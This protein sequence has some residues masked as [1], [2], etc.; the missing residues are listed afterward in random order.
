[1]EINRKEGGLIFSRIKKKTPILRLALRP[2]QS[3]LRGLHCNR[4]RGGGGPDG[5]VVI[6][7]RTTHR[8]RKRNRKIIDEKREKCR[9][10]NGSLRNTSPDWEEATLSPTSKARR[11]ASRNRFV[12]KGWMPNRVESLRE[13]DCS[14]NRLRARLGMLSPSEMD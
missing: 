13:V 4:N 7:K 9:T 10:K 2:N 5:Q 11:E 1:M 3:S 8:R 14:K 12:K 6:T